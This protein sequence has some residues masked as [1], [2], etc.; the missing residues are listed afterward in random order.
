VTPYVSLCR[1]CASLRVEDRRLPD[2]AQGVRELFAAVGDE[3]DVRHVVAV[4]V[5]AAAAGH[6]LLDPQGRPHDAV[7]LEAGAGDD[8]FARHR[9]TRLQRLLAGD[10]VGALDDILAHP[11]RLA[12]LA[13]VAALQGGNRFALIALGRLL[14]R[15]PLG[16]PSAIDDDSL[17]RQRPRRQKLAAAH[18]DGVS[19]RLARRD[20][21]AGRYGVGEGALLFERQV[22]GAGANAVEIVE[23]HVIAVL[24]EHTARKRLQGAANLT[25]TVVGGFHRFSLSG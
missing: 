21:Q 25:R 17:A 23:L 3:N 11:C 4:H 22:P 12:G 20:H 7:Q 1:R 15:H 16:F 10:L 13:L 2:Q 6:A 18:C 5:R 24:G 14:E 19:R 8:D 9:F